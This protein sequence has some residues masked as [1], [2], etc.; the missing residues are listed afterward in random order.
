MNADVLMK[1]ISVAHHN[2]LK[3]LSMLV[4]TKIKP[5]FPQNPEGMI[6]LAVV[7]NALRDS[8]DFNGPHV[9]EARRFLSKDIPHADI[10][11]V[12]SSYILRVIM[13]IGLWDS[14]PMRLR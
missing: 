5:V 6:M 10:C 7:E 1:K 3:I 2:Q 12:E 4:I 13:D 8:I 11:N 9:E 14:T